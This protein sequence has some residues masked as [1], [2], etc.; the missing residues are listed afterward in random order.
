MCLVL[1]LHQRGRRIPSQIADLPVWIVLQNTS[2]CSR[3]VI[4]QTQAK[5]ARQYCQF[6]NGNQEVWRAICCECA[7]ILQVKARQQDSLHIAVGM[8]QRGF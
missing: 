1:Q 3:E 6:L 7:C 5:Y 2:A 4:A 8:Y